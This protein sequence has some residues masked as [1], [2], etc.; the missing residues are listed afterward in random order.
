MYLSNKLVE[1]QTLA[2]DTHR[3]HVDIGALADLSFRWTVETA[4]AG[5]NAATIAFYPSELAIGDQIF[6][7]LDIDPA[8][9]PYLAVDEDAVFNLNP[10]NVVGSSVLKLGANPWK[11]IV[12]EIVCTIEIPRFSF[13]YGGRSGGR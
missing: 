5:P 4:A 12:I 3:W 10:G 9:N 11:S 8:G 1:R 2:V 7:D 6:R 13:V